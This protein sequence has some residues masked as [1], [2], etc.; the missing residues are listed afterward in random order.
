MSKVHSGMRLHALSS[1][2]TEKFTGSIHLLDLV[3]SVVRRGNDYG[4]AAAVWV[5]RDAAAVAFPW[6]RDDQYDRGHQ[7]PPDQIAYHVRHGCPAL[8]HSD[9]GLVDG[10]CDA[11]PKAE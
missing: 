2:I 6:S 3:E 5:F 7:R 1:F 8:S 9:A 4:D 10:G 11:G